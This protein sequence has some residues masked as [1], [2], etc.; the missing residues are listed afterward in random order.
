VLT[1]SA[2]TSPLCPRNRHER[3]HPLGRGPAGH[4][5]GSDPGT[6]PDGAW[7]VNQVRDVSARSG[8][9]SGRASYRPGRGAASS[10]DA[11]GRV[12]PCD[13]SKRRGG[14]DFPRRQGSAPIP[15]AARPCRRALRVALPRLLPHGHAL[16]P[17]DRGHPRGSLRGHA[18]AERGLRPA[19]QP[20]LRPPRT[21]VRRP[22]RCVGDRG[23]G[24]PRSSRALH[25]R[26]PRT[27]GSL[28]AGRRLAVERRGGP[29]GARSPRSPR[30]RRTAARRPRPS[31][32]P[33]A[34]RRR[35]ARRPRSS[36]RSRR[37]RP[38]RPS[39]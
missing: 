14:V 39:S 7:R 5:R 13:Y 17:R 38:G 1:L 19:V 31:S 8:R 2:C 24:P 36:R 22:L 3:P 26:E 30:G 27:R 18:R 37:G 12:L 33:A 23:R 32:V 29:R 34:G 10:A 35:G 20:T 25:P 4:V 6:W 9:S 28:R 21:C 11:S 16:P 15:L